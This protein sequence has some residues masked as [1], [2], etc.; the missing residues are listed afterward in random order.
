MMLW[1]YSWEGCVCS[2]DFLTHDERHELSKNPKRKVMLVKGLF[3]RY[4]IRTIWG[5]GGIVLVSIL[6]IAATMTYRGG[7]K[8]T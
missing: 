8:R 2:G 7:Y 4:L 5:M 6:C 1:R 3:I